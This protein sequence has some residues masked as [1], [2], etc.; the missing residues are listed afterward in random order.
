M[1][2]LGTRFSNEGFILPKPLILVNGK[3]LIE[4]SINS[5]D[6]DAQY[7]FVTRRYEN[8]LHNEQ[9][10]ETLKRVAPGCVERIIDRPTR[11]SVETC[12]FAED[13]INTKDSLIITNCD[14]ITDWESSDFL[15]FISNDN[16]DGIVV[17]YTS[18]NPKNSFAVVK[19]GRVVS[20]VEKKAVSDTALIGLHYWK[21]GSDFVRSGKRLL[22]EFTES[23][24][25]ECY[26]SETYNYLINEGMFIKAYHIDSNQYISLGTPY[27]LSIYEGKIKEFHI[28]KPSTILCDIDGT[29]IKHA[30]R[31]SDLID[32]APQLLSGVIEKINQWDSQG[33]R[34][35]F[36]TARKESA[37]EMTEKQLRGLGLCWD[38]LIMGMTSGKRVL[39][40]DKLNKKH[41]NRAVGIN[42]I[43]DAGFG[44]IDWKEY[45]L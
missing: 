22:Q 12:L 15:S 7:I 43:T 1:A 35:V 14:Q 3:T 19:N 25:P 9:L 4:H 45:S 39:I 32:T 41:P 10:S 16:L 31:F 11:G 36:M 30:H 26:I 29:I 38:Q 28:D 5:L 37:R 21:R 2:G 23:G 42:L 40:N 6:I 34:I 27:D 8:P 13:L 33:H 20:I 17:T 18:T 44:S 24:R